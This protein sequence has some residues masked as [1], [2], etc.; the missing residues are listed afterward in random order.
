MGEIELLEED[1]NAGKPI[2]ALRVHTKFTVTE[3]KTA[4]NKSVLGKDEKRERLDKK[5]WERKLK[6]LTDGKEKLAGIE[7]PKQKPIEKKREVAKPRKKVH[8]SK[9]KLR[10]ARARKEKA[11]EEK[12]KAAEKEKEEEE[13]EKEEEAAERK[14]KAEKKKEAKGEGGGGGEGEA[15]CTRCSQGATCE[16]R[17][18]QGE[19]CEARCCA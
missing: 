10:E 2:H 19:T 17:C 6:T 13:K 16:A 15:G 18:S 3:K 5:K 1:K 9:K 14:K 8:V 12:E 11:E 4:R 7:V